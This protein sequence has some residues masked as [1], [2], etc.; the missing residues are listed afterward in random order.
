MEGSLASVGLY[1]NR[2]MCETG[3]MLL[4]KLLVW[5]LGNQALTISEHQLSSA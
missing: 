2:E 3:E 5:D 4:L 1:I